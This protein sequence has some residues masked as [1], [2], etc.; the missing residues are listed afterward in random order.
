MS[1]F[2]LH[3]EDFIPS[4]NIPDGEATHLRCQ[5]ILLAKQNDIY[6]QHLNPIEK[7]LCSFELYVLLPQYT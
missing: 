1:F 5:S 3:N 7:D 4:R 6:D 2:Y